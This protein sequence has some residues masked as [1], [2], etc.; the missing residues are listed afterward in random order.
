VRSSTWSTTTRNRSTKLRTFLMC[1]P[2]TVKTRMFYARK[3]LAELVDFFFTGRSAPTGGLHCQC[4]PSSL[5]PWSQGNRTSQRGV[6]NWSHR[7]R[8]VQAL[9]KSRAECGRHGRPPARAHHPRIASH[10]VALIERCISRM[11]I[12]GERCRFQ[13]RGPAR[14]FGFYEP[15]ETRR[16]SFLL[17]R[18]RS[19]QLRQ[20]LPD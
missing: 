7:R 11:S 12:R 14:N 16:G 18:N 6:A 9:G 13:N 8:A 4:A 15:R 2:A 10:R 19:T 1:P 5:M 17:G 20:S 3:K